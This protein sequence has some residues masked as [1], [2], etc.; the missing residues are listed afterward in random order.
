MTGVGPGRNF[1]RR[2]AAQQLDQ[3]SAFQRTDIRPSRRPFDQPNILAVNR[4]VE[5]S[6]KF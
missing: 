5:F 2:V 6:I 4:S 1:C 3:V